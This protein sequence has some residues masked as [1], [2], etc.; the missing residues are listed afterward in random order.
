MKDTCKIHI[1]Y[2][3]ITYR[4]NIPLYDVIVSSTPVGL[5]TNGTVLI[6]MALDSSIAFT[7]T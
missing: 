5:T 6:I 7:F 1:S 4:I 2:L 3:M